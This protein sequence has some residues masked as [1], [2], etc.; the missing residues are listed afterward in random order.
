[1]DGSFHA[2]FPQDHFQRAKI[3]KRRLQQVEPHE[4]GEPEPI[5]AVIVG[6]READEDEGARK[7]A[8]DEMHFHRC[9][10]ISRW[11]YQRKDI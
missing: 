7:T 6:E 1:M 5:G 8:D 10:T 11:T 3:R 9:Q 4:R 2:Q